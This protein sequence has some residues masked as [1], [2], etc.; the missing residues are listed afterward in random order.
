[1]K[2]YAAKN[3]LVYVNYYDAMANADGGMKANLAS[4]GVHPTKAGYEIMA[5][6]AEKGIAQALAN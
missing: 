5:P 6:L 3:N 4:D 1:M 2:D